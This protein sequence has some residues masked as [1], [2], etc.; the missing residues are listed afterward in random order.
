MRTFMKQTIK[1]KHYSL[2]IEKVGL[3]PMPMQFSLFANIVIF[4]D[5]SLSCS[6]TSQTWQF[7]SV[8]LVG[9]CFIISVEATSFYSKS[10]QRFF[11][12]GTPQDG[13]KFF[14]SR[15]HLQLNLNQ[16]QN[17]FW[18]SR[19]RTWNKTKTSAQHSAV[20]AQHQQPAQ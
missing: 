12:Q 16:N 20:N 15:F 18:N 13:Y 11:I 19:I 14:L 17:Y 3:P 2:V 10:Q 7:Q 8:A 9:L 1:R 4:D 6:G 5:K